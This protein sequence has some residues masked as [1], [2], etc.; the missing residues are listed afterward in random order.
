MEKTK[1]SKEKKKKML[2]S[3]RLR[4]CRDTGMLRRQEIRPRFWLER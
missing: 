4:R 1:E 2:F 3:E